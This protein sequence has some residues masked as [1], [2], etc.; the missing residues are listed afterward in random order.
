M[1][2]IPRD[3]VADSGNSSTPTV[4]APLFLFAPPPKQPE[5]IPQPAAPV[6]PTGPQ[7]TCFSCGLKNPSTNQVCGGSGNVGCN[8]PWHL[9]G[10]DGM[11]IGGSIGMKGKGKKIGS[12]G[13]SGTTKGKDKWEPS[14]GKGA[15]AGPYSDA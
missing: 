4:D 2:A 14:K 10:D 5:P 12:G 11:P 6:V 1:P 8:L 15:R 3:P 13:S 7:W 9:V